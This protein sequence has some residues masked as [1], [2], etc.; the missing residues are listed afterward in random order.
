MRLTHESKSHTQNAFT[1]LTYN[2]ENLPNN[3]DLEQPP[4]G[5][6]VPRDLQ[7]FIKRL[8]KQNGETR[9]KYFACGEYGDKTIRPHYHICFFNYYPPDPVHHSTKLENKLY[10]SKSLDEIWGKG[11]TLTG[12]LTFQSAAYVARYITKKINGPNSD[13]HYKTIDTRTGQIT[14]RLPEF[15]RQSNGLGK[16]HFNKYTEDIYNH[17]HVILSDGKKTRPP[18]YYDK[19]YQ[20]KNPDHLTEIKTT[21][22]AKALKH[23]ANNTPERLAVREKIQQ[24]KAR[25]LLRS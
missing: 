22:E 24:L 20:E 5:T 19:L 4:T 25:R 11:F 6:L 16:A 8:R 7:L 3:A 23:F 17:D 21:R 1:T 9:L 2:D 18:R 10:S 13:D 12:E 14:Q 15:T